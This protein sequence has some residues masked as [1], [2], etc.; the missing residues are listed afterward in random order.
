MSLNYLETV[1]K[2]AP[3]TRWCTYCLH[4]F[5]EGEYKKQLN[6]IIDCPKCRDGKLTTHRSKVFSNKTPTPQIKSLGP[7]YLNP[8]GET[9][10]HKVKLAAGVVAFN[11]YPLIER[12]LDSL[13]DFDHVIICEGKYDINPFG[14]DHSTDGTLEIIYKY[15]NVHIL[16]CAGMRQSD[17][18]NM[19]IEKAIELG[20]DHLLVIECDE[21]LTGDM[22]EFRDNLPTHGQSGPDKT[23][24]T[25]FMN[26]YPNHIV[27]SPRF[28]YGL[29]HFR[30]GQTHS[31]Y[32]IDGE[33][34]FARNG[35]TIQCSNLPGILVN[36]D[37]LPR[38]EE[39]QNKALYYQMKLAVQEKQEREEL[40]GQ[41]KF[42]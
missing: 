22:Q 5:K 12:M 3:N 1:Y 2:P 41:G 32:I 23:V 36:H 25:T 4:E 14:M 13:V 35:N 17:V 11:D 6:N 31:T 15:P 27:K 7:K 10:N 39:Q 20:C 37:E 33:T 26:Y 34:W 16:D 40:K 8:I 42:L 18:R 21:Y 29:K 24:Y 9:K 30:Y 19:Y 38:T 28:F